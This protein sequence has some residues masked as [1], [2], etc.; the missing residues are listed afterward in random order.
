MLLPNLFGRFRRRF[1]QAFL[2]RPIDQLGMKGAR[3]R[4]KPRQLMQPRSWPSQPN[5]WRRRQKAVQVAK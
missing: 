5:H 4:S 2:S 3:R 1:F